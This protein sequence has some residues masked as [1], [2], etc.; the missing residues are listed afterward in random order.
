[1]R[2]AGREVGVVEV[3]GFHAQCCEFAEEV[4]EDVRVVVDALEQHGLREENAT[5]FVEFFEGGFDLRCD[6]LRV[7]DM[8]RDVNCFLAFQ[9]GAE[10]IGDAFRVGGGEE[11]EGR[12][13]KRGGCAPPLEGTGVGPPEVVPVAG[14]SAR[15]TRSGSGA[16]RK[17]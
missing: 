13:Q 10:F 9:C 7:V 16:S 6:F 4:F 3:I 15:K 1:M 12:A 5:R 11:S 17:R 8:D 14:S 2:R